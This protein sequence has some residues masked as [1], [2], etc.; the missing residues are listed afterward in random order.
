MTLTTRL[1]LSE[2]V[3]YTKGIKIGNNTLNTEFTL[4][5]IDSDKIKFTYV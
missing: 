5:V 3:I 1:W 4:H 2:C